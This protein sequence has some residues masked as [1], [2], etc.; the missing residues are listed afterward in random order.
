MNQLIISK[1]KELG[2]KLE[3]IENS[4]V[5]SFKKMAY[6]K[7]AKAIEDLKDNITSIDQLK[8]VKG[9]GPSILFKIDEIIKTGTL[10]QLDS[11]TNDYTQL[12]KVQ[13]IGPVKAKELYDTYKIKTIKELENLIQT[14]VII[15]EKLEHSVQRALM[16]KEER[17]PLE[18]AKD[19]ASE[20]ELVLKLVAPRA[21]IQTAGS[22]RRKKATIKDID[23]IF[24]GDVM[25]IKAGIAAY[26][27][28][29]WDD[30]I[31]DGATRLSAIKD[32]IEVDI[33]FIDKSE[34]G[35]CLLY[36]T[37]PQELNIKMRQKAKDMGLRLNEYGLFDSAGVIIASK[38][39]KEIFDA[40]G[41][42]YLEPEQR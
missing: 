20:V 5:I 36:F 40:L 29:K 27:G 8:G 1:L 16:I 10:S 24:A 9:I 3:L 19:I 7:A 15:D 32:G 17:I 21:W 42:T 25:D 4:P 22:I 34:Y 35:S 37:G 38:T 2:S 13:G 11:I 39:E 33:R 6:F 41:M 12:L 14:K 28:I 23:I 18:K 26:K 30:I 31:M